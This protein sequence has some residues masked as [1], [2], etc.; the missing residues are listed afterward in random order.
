MPEFVLDMGTSEA[1]RDFNKLDSF[2]RGYIE[3]AFWTDA[4]AD[5]SE[6][7]EGA[8][9][10]ELADE[11]LTSIIEDCSA[12][13]K[14]NAVM[15]EQAYTSELVAYDES[16]AGTDFWLTRNRHGAGY[17]D[18]GL[19]KIGTAL[20]DAAHVYGTSSLYRGDTGAVHVS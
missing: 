19:G 11:S 2:T 4:N 15:L 8:T 1:A 9:F 17:W 14:D 20:S 10:A 13:Q 5:M 18:R 3:A 6:D 7:L 12:F 16:R